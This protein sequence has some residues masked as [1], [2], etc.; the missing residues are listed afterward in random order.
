MLESCIRRRPRNNTIQPDSASILKPEISGATT[1]ET[2]SPQPPARIGLFYDDEAYV[3]PRGRL[4]PESP[5]GPLGLMGRQVAGQTF[6]EALLRH[7][8]FSELVALV[9]ER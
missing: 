5:E 1:I 6:L 7:G 2:E 4:R 9:R 8:T 3:V